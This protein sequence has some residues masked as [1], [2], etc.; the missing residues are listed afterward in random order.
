MLAQ[1]T[2]LFL[3]LLCLRRMVRGETL[4]HKYAVSRQ[5]VPGEVGG[6]FKDVRLYA[7]LNSGHSWALSLAIDLPQC[8]EPRWGAQKE[9]HGTKNKRKQ[10]KHTQKKTKINRKKK[11][12][13]KKD[14]RD[15]TNSVFFGENVA[16]RP[17]PFQVF[18]GVFR[19]FQMFWFLLVSFGVQDSWLMTLWTGKFWVG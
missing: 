2:F 1:T 4:G 8:H 5:A 12:T 18:S 16:G 6:K 13:T 14:T 15:G 19:C 9:S 10:R 17:T 7:I 11:K 3:C